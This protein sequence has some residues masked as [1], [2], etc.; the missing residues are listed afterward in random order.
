MSL[1][2]GSKGP[3]VTKLQTQLNNLKDARFAC[4]KADGIFGAGTEKA[5]KAFQTASKLTADGIV[6]KNTHA[7][8]DKATATVAGGGKIA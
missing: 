4:G 1:Q 2:S 6:G 7:A 3:E 8:L 5:V